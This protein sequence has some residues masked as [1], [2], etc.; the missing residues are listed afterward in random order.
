LLAF[1]IIHSRSVPSTVLRPLRSSALSFVVFNTLFG[2]AVPI[3]DQWAHMGGLVTGFL[4]GLVLIRPWPVIRS[5][6]LSL[7]RLALGLALAGAIL[8]VGIGAVRWRERT[9]PPLP[10]FKDFTEQIAPAI[11]EFNAVW[12]A[13]PEVGRLQAEAESSQ[14]RQGLSRTLRDLQTRATANLDQLRRIATPHPSLQASR[15]T[16]IEGQTGQLATL[17]ASLEYLDTRDRKCLTGPG[18]VL[19]GRAAMIRSSREF[20]KRQL[21]YLESHGL[22]DHNSDPGR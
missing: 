18:G 6:W 3:I 22:M 15:Q 7:R 12:Q 20:E 5:P 13:I 16:L 9:L 1:L 2:V 14:S 19:A 21:A 11:F 8:G 10:R 17:A 4:G